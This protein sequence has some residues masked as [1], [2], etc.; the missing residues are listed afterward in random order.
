MGHYGVSVLSISQSLLQFLRFPPPKL[1]FWY[2]PRAKKH[3]VAE[4]FVKRCKCCACTSQGYDGESGLTISQPLLQSLRF[5]CSKLSPFI[6]IAFHQD[7]FEQGVVLF[8]D[9]WKSGWRSQMAD[10]CRGVALSRHIIPVPTDQ[11]LKVAASHLSLS[12]SISRPS[13]PCSQPITRRQPLVLSVPFHY[14]CLRA[15]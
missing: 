12:L 9:F 6:N 14:R 5:L 11:I 15:S 4:P 13:L 8:R 3:N 7:N 1:S 10:G 2:A